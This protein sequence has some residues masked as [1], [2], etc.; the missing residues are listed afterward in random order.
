MR[1]EES[2]GS[3]GRQ[4][5]HAQP[6]KPRADR[7]ADPRRDQG[8]L[9][10][11]AGL[12]ESTFGRLV[13]NDGKLLSAACGTGRASP[14]IR[15]IACAATWP[16]IAPRVAAA[17]TRAA[18]ATASLPGCPERCGVTFEQDRSRRVSASSI[19]V[20]STSCS[21][22]PAARS[23]RW[24]DRVALELAHIFTEAAGA[25][26][27]RC[28]CRRRHSPGAGNAGGMHARFPTMPFYVVGKEIS[29][30]DIRLTLDKMADRFFEHP[31]T[32]LV[33]TNLYYAEAPW[34]T[35]RAPAAAHSF[36]WKDVRL[37]GVSSGARIRRADHGGLGAVPQRTLARRPKP[38]DRK[39]GL[40]AAGRV[41]LPG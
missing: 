9:P 1:I 11:D 16:S 21:S 35:P 8:L 33:L 40:R 15:S 34:L 23:W 26:P 28:R 22:I 12:A 37:T 24:A 19:S 7:R 41:P 32:V 27:V 13:V 31:S 30:E 20:R 17:G 38:Q 18:N 14:P 4:N 39:S 36:V 6:A 29:L 5:G 3:N 2:Q 10:L 25:A